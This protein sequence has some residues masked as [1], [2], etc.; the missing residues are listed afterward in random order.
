MSERSGQVT[1]KSRRILKRFLWVCGCGLVLVILVFGFAA[2]PDQI[3]SVRKPVIDRIRF[4]MPKGFLDPGTYVNVYPLGSPPVCPSTSTLS[5]PVTLAWP[6]SNTTVALPGIP[7]SSEEPLTLET[8]QGLLRPFPNVEL[9]PPNDQD[10]AQ[11]WNKTTDDLTSAMLAIV[12][13]CREASF[14]VAMNR[15]SEINTARWALFKDHPFSE[16]S[17]I[18]SRQLTRSNILWWQALDQGRLRL[19]VDHGQW[20]GAA[21]YSMCLG[22]ADNPALWDTEVYCL[23]QCGIRGRVMLAQQSTRP[24]FRPVYRFIGQSN[25]EYLGN[26]MHRALKSVDTTLDQSQSNL[27]DITQFPEQ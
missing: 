27:L 3:R 9:L 14:T 6:T 25:M 4:S 2:G 15:M 23:R 24:I 1:R 21:Y 8:L 12:S 7:G 10:T 5:L 18:L 13:D 20:E 11:T 22:A 19:S 16:K 17:E 26:R